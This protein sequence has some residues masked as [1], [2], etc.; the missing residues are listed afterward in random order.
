M[1]IDSIDYEPKKEKILSFDEAKERLDKM[2]EG[3]SESMWQNELNKIQ[4]EMGPDNFNASAQDFFV[5]AATTKKDDRFFRTLARMH[6][7]L[8]LKM[9]VDPTQNKQLAFAYT[10]GR[11]DYVFLQD[12]IDRLTDEIQDIGQQ[13]EAD[14]DTRLDG[15]LDDALNNKGLV[16][17][18]QKKLDT[19]METWRSAMLKA[20]LN[21]KGGPQEW[22]RNF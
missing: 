16:E 3:A 6:P 9:S 4:K 21:P 2:Y 1:G 11:Y 7:E 12:E 20:G 18:K 8:S 13:R 10:Q 5:W 22:S 17:N 19:L 15:D 14:F